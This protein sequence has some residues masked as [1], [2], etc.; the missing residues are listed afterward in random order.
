ML[1]KVLQTGV[2]KGEIA[3][4]TD[5]EKQSAF[6]LGIMQGLSVASKTMDTEQLSNFISVAVKQIK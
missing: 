1:K 6:F 2:E 3:Q 4:D 5:I